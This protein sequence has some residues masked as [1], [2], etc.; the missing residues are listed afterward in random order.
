MIKSM[1]QSFLPEAKRFSASEIP[2]ILGNLKV[3]CRCHQSPRA[4]PCPEPDPSSP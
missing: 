2:L 3:Q 4:C 1:E